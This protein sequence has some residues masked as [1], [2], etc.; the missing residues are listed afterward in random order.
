MSLTKIAHKEKNMPL[1]QLP[2]IEAIRCLFKKNSK[3]KYTEKDVNR[4]LNLPDK[5]TTGIYL[6]QLHK[7]GFLNQDRSQFPVRYNL[8][9]EAGLSLDY[10]YEKIKE[11]KKRADQEKKQADERSKEIEITLKVLQ[12]LLPKR[13]Q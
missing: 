10:I 12:E 5:S 1:T 3:T 11:D 7:E 2:I 13:V 6:R 9:E 8:Q 4:I